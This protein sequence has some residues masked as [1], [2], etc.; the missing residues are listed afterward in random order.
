MNENSETVI[1]VAVK[2]GNKIMVGLLLKSGDE[3]M[4]SDA[5]IAACRIMNKEIVELLL[6]SDAHSHLDMHLQTECV[7]ICAKHGCNR[8]L[9]MLHRNG[10]YLRNT[11]R[12]VTLKSPEAKGIP[13]L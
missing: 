6:E 7:L 3:G 11:G 4:C 1:E 2:A 13:L 12:L 5:F 10:F 9:K 8:I